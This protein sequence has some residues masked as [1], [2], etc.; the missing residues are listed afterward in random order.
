V[1]WLSTL[2]NRSSLLLA[3]LFFIC[4]SSNSFAVDCQSGYPSTT[5]EFKWAGFGSETFPSGELACASSS[6]MNYMSATSVDTSVQSE[7]S[8]KC[9]F[10]P[11]GQIGFSNRSAGCADGYNLVGSQ[12]VAACTPPAECPTAGTTKNSSV[13]V[14]GIS[15]QQGIGA[16]MCADSGGSSCGI[17]CNSGIASYNDVSGQSSVYCDSY[18][19]TGSACTSAPVAAPVTS[20][21]ATNQATPINSPPKSKQDCPGGSGF[22]EVNNVGMCLPSGT[23]FSGG[24]TTQTSSGGSVS[25]SSVTT[26][27]AGGTNTTTTVTTYKDAAGNVT[28]SGTGTSTGSIN[29]AVTGGGIGQGDKPSFGDAPTFDSTLPQEATLNIKAQG[30]PVF[31]T[32]IFA[33]TPSCPAPITY[34]AMGQELSIDF[35][36]I[37]AFSDVIR[38]IILL[39]SAVTAMRSLVTS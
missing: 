4:F 36:S 3:F 22:A 27:N 14:S 31:S 1:I 13:A 17:K 6:Y 33:S 25:T 37:C 23:Q 38:G 15:G 34:T 26:V 35:A 28:Y 19:F 9:T 5:P 11:H 18:E 12:C 24:A 7:T 20:V 21:P 39:L 8:V 32:E 16:S 10:Q 29:Q 30:N 2:C